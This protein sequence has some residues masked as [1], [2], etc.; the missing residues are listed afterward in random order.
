MHLAIKRNR[1][2]VSIRGSGACGSVPTGYF[3]KNERIYWQRP[4]NTPN[5]EDRSSCWGPDHNDA[6]PWGLGG[7]ARD[8]RAFPPIASAV[9][10]VPIDMI[11][12]ICSFIDVSGSRVYTEKKKI[13]TARRISK[14]NNNIK[15][16]IRTWS[17]S[18]S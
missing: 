16:Q 9:G 6:P 2:F 17:L 12:G 15:V 14:N 18:A 10:H 7:A 4:H 5:E 3:S 13:Q 8:F 1:L 11:C